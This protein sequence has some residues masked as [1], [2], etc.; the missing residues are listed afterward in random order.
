[1]P[2]LKEKK[3]DLVKEFQ[4]H[5]KDTGNSAIQIAILTERIELLTGHLKTY[6]KDFAS[7]QGLFRMVGQRR[8][9]LGYLKKTEPARYQALIQRLELR[10]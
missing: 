8:Q 3:K 10:K 2:Q 7:R 9:L 1:M 4:N 5:A 6:P